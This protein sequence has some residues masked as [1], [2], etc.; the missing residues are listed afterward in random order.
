MAQDPYQPPPGSEYIPPP[1]APIYPVTS[2]IPPSS[3]YHYSPAPTGR[4]NRGIVGGLLAAIVAVVS[5][6][7]AVLALL[8]KVPAMGTI[9]S[10]VVSFGGYALFW[11]WQFAAA[12]VAMI[13]IHEMGHVI[14]IQR[15]GMKATAPIFIP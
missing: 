8:L 12:L 10:L 7:G 13:L 1:P 15:Q 11:G 2:D 14:E 3:P 4:P 6:G 9:L 5:K